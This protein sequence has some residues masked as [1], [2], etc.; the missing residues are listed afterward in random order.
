LNLLVA[1]DALLAERSITGAATRLNL[2]QSATSGILG[3]LRDYFGDELL[4]QVGRQM[5][6]TPLAVSL[7]AR[8]RHV[9][10]TVH[11]TIINREDFDPATSQRHFR[12]CASDFV[13]TVLMTA[14]VRQLEREA[15]GITLEMTSPDGDPLG[16]LD[17]GELDFLILPEYLLEKQHPKVSLFE[18]RHTC[19]VWTGNRL[20]KDTLSFEQYM[21]LGHVVVRIG[22]RPQPTFEEW[23][24][25]QF[26]HT[27]RVEIVTDSFNSL[28]QFIF[29]T[30]RI[31]TVHERL[32]AFYARTL[33]LRL[34]PPPVEIP[35]MIE[36]LQ[37]HKYLDGDAGHQWMLNLIRRCAAS[38]IEGAAG[39]EPL[40]TPG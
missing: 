37:W 18:S 4:V 10:V 21:E 6:P 39:S 27:R 32:A 3:R 19:V 13:K 33:E 22:A 14:V 31:A 5:M 15:P 34:I 38:G 24:I 29:G 7:S 12:I 16:Q 23:F 25:K 9:L 1:L 35:V 11:S 17:R 30:Q 28:P 8:V 26:G 20:V 40:S 36:G 2:S